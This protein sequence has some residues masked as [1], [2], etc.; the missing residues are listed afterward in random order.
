MENDGKTDIIKVKAKELKQAPWRFSEN[1]AL[2]HGRTRYFTRILENI[3]KSLTTAGQLSPIHVRAIPEGYEIVDGHIVVDAAVQAGLSELEAIVHENLTDEEARLLYIHFNLN[4]CGQYSHYH[5]KIHRVFGEVAG[6]DA[7]EK[8]QA[9]SDHCNWPS[10][11]ILD[12]V[13]LSERDEN[14]RRFM[15]STD[16]DEPVED[17]R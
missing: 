12:Y 8:A 14:W 5:V 17:W 11:R 13:E 10:T 15:Y 16:S 7:K 1:R 4:R 3:V 2:A 6:A 9:I